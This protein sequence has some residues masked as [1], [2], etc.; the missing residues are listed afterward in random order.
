MQF[1]AMGFNMKKIVVIIGVILLILVGLKFY[2]SEY[3]KLMKPAIEAKNKNP[4]LVFD[5]EIEP[6]FPDREENDK[7][8]LGVDVNNNGVRDDVDIWINRTFMYADQRKALKQYAKSYITELIE[9]PKLDKKLAFDLRQES[10]ARVDC[11]M[12]VFHA[13]D[14]NSSKTI[15]NLR[16]IIQFPDFRD[17]ADFLQHNLLAGQVIGDIEPSHNSP[18]MYCKFNV[19][20]K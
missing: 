5:G 4:N 10:E 12:S 8:I 17:K 19:E 20:K 9:A 3:E 18:F 16:S 2:P 15:S 1:F 13:Y 6:P 11:L 7:T 14:M